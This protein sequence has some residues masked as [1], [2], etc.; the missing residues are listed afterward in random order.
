MAT[1]LRALERLE[2]PENESGKPTRA[3]VEAAVRT[4]IRWT[5]ENPNRDGLR[6]TPA[7]VTR[8]FEEFFSGYSQDPTEILKKTFEEIEGYDE[9]IVLR[10]IPFESHCE[11]HMAPIIGKAW[12]AYIPTGRVVGISKLARLVEAYARRLQIQ[13]KM[14]AQI[15]NTIDDVLKPQGVGVII[16]AVHHCMTTRGIH[17]PGTDM[18]TSRMLGVFRDNALT[19]Q[20]FLRMAE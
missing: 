9:M 6:E 8:A 16:K 2:S 13:E 14:T 11:H 15:A 20:E 10:G 5:G 7:R 1:N 4:M 17:K 19:R 3:E 18:V 12:V